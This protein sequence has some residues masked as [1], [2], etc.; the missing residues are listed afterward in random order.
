MFI[1]YQWYKV[2]FKRREERYK[3]KITLRR[4][5]KEEIEEFGEK[6][7]RHPVS[8]NWSTKE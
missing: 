6:P 8:G 4:V 2:K 3:H 1:H 5:I 7:L